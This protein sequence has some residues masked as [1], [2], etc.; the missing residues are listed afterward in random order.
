MGTQA[1]SVL[2]SV[3]ENENFKKDLKKVKLNQNKLSTNLK[4]TPFTKFYSKLP[5]DFEENEELISLLLKD[6]D[7]MSPI[8]KN[9]VKSFNDE[10]FLRFMT[11]LQNKKKEQKWQG[12]G[13][14]S[15]HY[16]DNFIFIHSNERSSLNV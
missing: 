2:K 12:N 7:K 6:P 3:K 8:E 9:Y 4:K 14:G 16:L 10:E 11:F 13:Y 15:G 1:L 5:S